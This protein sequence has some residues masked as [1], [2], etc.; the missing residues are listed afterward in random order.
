M[1]LARAVAA[2]GLAAALS[3]GAATLALPAR[4]QTSFAEIGMHR[5]GT[6]TEWGDLLRVNAMR[7]GRDA[8]MATRSPVQSGRIEV[9]IIVASDGTILAVERLRSSFD[10]AADAVVLDALREMDRMPPFPPDMAGAE[11]QFALPINI[12]VR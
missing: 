1:T 8:L 11:Q 9:T 5:P 3:M 2:G 7:R 12:A 6:V 10:A 4:A